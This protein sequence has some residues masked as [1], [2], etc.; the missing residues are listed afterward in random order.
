MDNERIVQMLSEPFVSSPGSFKRH[1]VTAIISFTCSDRDFRGP[2][3]EFHARFEEAGV[4]RIVEPG[5]PLILHLEL[6][7]GIGH[8][9]ERAEFLIKHHGITIA[10]LFGHDKCGAYADK[11]GPLGW[12][13]EKINEQVKTDLLDVKQSLKERFGD[14]LKVFLFFAQPEGDCVRFIPL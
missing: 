1:P 6:T 2:M 5:G 9:I 7:E 4:D 8:A 14:K 13:Q 12:S 11:Y 3:A 10:V